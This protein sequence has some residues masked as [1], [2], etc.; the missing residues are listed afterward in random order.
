MTGADT[1]AQGQGWQGGNFSAV[2]TAVKAIMQVLRAEL[3]ERVAG[4]G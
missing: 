3:S 4:S 2:Q 1:D